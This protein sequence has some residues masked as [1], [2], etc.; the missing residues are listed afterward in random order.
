[1]LLFKQATLYLTNEPTS[2]Q[3]WRWIRWRCPRRKARRNRQHAQ[4]QHQGHDLHVSGSGAAHATRRAHRQR[5]LVGLETWTP[6]HSNLWSHQGGCGQPYLVPVKRS[7]LLFSFNIQIK[8][9][10]NIVFLWFLAGSQPRH[11][12]QRHWPRPRGDR[13]LS[14]RA[15]GRGDGVRGGGDAGCGSIWDD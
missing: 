14:A 3:C 1:M 12:R 13:H 5:L 10:V 7:M 8:F 9:V 15:P 11:H 6:C 2:E 4:Y